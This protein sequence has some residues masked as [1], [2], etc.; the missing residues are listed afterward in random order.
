[1]PTK[2]RRAKGLG[3]LYKRG[4]IYWMAYYRNRRQ[5]HES[6]GTKDKALALRK[7][8]QRMNT[9]DSPE[10]AGPQ[11]ERITVE[12]LS[13][14]FLR[15]YRNNGRKSYDDAEARWRLHLCP[16]FGHLRAV[17]VSPDSISK[18]V[19]ARLRDGAKNATVNREL[20]AL[21]RMF[22][23][24][25]QNGLIYQVPHFP[26]LEENNVRTGFV[27]DGQYQALADACGNYGLWLRAMFEVGY[28][29]GW[30]DREIRDLRVRQ[31]DIAAG[32]IRL[33]T[34]TTK[35][36]GGREVTMSANV[37]TLLAACIAGKKS[38]DYV[39]TRANG[40][41]IRAFKGA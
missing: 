37:K 35:N 1:M 30:R 20:A 26:R 3:G 36:K 23:L 6:T 5:V 33:E 40:K 14:G 12:N 41:P 8:K 10:F 15:D 24:G 32:I 16:V 34:G 11:V 29:Y 13:E 27:E 38:P 17:A 18:Y 39:F 28:T 9:K 2:K 21:K 25:K 7:L 31:V 4:D 22:H 19:D